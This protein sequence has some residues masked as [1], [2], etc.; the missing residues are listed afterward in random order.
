[1]YRWH[2]LFHDYYA[3]LTP[4]MVE[5][6]IECMFQSMRKIQS[7]MKQA[8]TVLN[9]CLKNRVMHR[10]VKPG[11]FF[12][13]DATESLTLGDFDCATLYPDRVRSSKI[14]TEGFMSPEM[15]HER[16]YTWKNDV[17]SLGVVFGMLLYRID[18]EHAVGKEVDRWRPMKTWK[19]KRKP[20]KLTKKPQYK[21]HGDVESRD[22][23]QKMIST[24]PEKRPSYEECL[25]HAFF[26]KVY[27]D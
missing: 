4:Y 15:V 1:M 9:E 14:G 3:Y 7:Y 8:L 24:R 21:F 2:E 23:L 25:E 20:Y 11:N 13:D 26:T 5:D 22:L 27:N 12:W 17:Y 6:D 16:G 10:D 19:H 18:D